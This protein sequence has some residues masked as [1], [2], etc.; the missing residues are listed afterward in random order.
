MLWFK[1][2]PKIYFKRGSLDLGLAEL[3]GWCVTVL[4][5]TQWHAA[6]G[7]GGLLRMCIA[8]TAALFTS[9]GGDDGGGRAEGMVPCMMRLTQRPCQSAVVVDGC[10]LHVQLALQNR[11][12]LLV[13]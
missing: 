10:C 4:I 13:C 12:L 1:A 3:K 7:G 5:L 2:P 11:H 8:D 9:R 6:S